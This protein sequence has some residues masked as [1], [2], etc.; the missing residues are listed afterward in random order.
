MLLDSFSTQVLAHRIARHARRLD[1]L[2]HRLLNIIY[3]EVLTSASLDGA[4][5]DA[6]AEGGWRAL[7]DTYSAAK[8][9]NPVGARWCKLAIEN[10]VC[11]MLFYME[12]HYYNKPLR[13]GALGS[14]DIDFT[15]R[16]KPIDGVGRAMR[17]QLRDDQWKQIEV[18]LPGKVGN[19]GRSGVEAVL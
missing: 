7:N 12:V 18:L 5:L 9:C 8:E 16:V 14:V 1:D 2:A 17:K 4:H 3:G 13:G 15:I 11:G 10:I 6:L 19:R